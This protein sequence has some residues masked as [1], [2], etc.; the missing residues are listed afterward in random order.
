M[1]NSGKVNN[2]TAT[3]KLNGDV[4]LVLDASIDRKFRHSLSNETRE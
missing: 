2:Q 1:E 4:T 3:Q